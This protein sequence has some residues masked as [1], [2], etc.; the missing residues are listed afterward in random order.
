MDKKNALDRI[1]K[2]REA[3]EEYRY[4]YH[5]EDRSIIPDSAL[6]T[7]KKE[8]VDLE[9]QFPDLITPDSPSQR[10]A[11]APSKKFKKVTHETRMTSLNDVF[12]AEE[13]KAWVVRLQ[14]F[15]AGGPFSVSTESEYY[16]E[17][18]LDG[19]AIELVYEDGIFVQ[20]ATRG[21]GLVGEDVTTNLKTVDAI[22]LALYP[23]ER[24][25]KNLKKYGLDPKK[26]E[27]APK[28]LVVRG[29]IFLT[30]QEFERI[31]KE[32][33]KR[34]EKIYANPRNVA[35]GS[36]RQLDP[37]ITAARK[38]DSYQYDIV[39][40]IGVDTH[41][42]THMV[43]SAFG[44]KVNPH[45]KKAKNLK[46]A[47]A[48]REY[49][50]EHRKKLPYEVDGTVIIVN[51]NN[52]FS[53]GGIIGKA[54]RGAVAFK[55]A[56]I[57]ATTI[58]E[59]IVVQVG[60]TGALTP[61]AVLRPVAVGG[62]MITHA[63][64]H[65]AD[66]VARLD[67]RIGDTVVVSRAGDVIPKILEVIKKLRPV[68]AKSFA[69]PTICPIDGSP[70][71]KEG[72][73]HKCTN[74][75]CGAR[76]K[77]GLYHFVSRKAFDIRGLGPKILDVFLD[78]GLIATAADIFDLH[79][80]DIEALPRFGEVSARNIVKEVSEK[81]NIE[82]SRFVYAL[83]IIHV[84]EETARL[85][86]DELAK[87]NEH[88]KN[89]TELYVTG[90]QFTKEELQSV[91]DIGPV[92]AESIYAWFHDKKNERFCEV[93]TRHGVVIKKE[94]KGKM[95]TLKNAS[96]VLTGSLQTMSREEAKEKIRAYG[97]VTHESVT[98]Q[99]SYVVAGEAPGSKYEKAKKLGVP[100][101]TEPDFLKLLGK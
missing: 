56:A 47:I 27:C 81:K 67:I 23:K 46:E 36:I 101:L 93:C 72:A 76:L 55:F 2:L 74:P 38:L 71:I 22:P 42:H 80:G 30:K 60:R 32:Q 8:L 99:T 25:E 75:Y 49:W 33:E 85:L 96:F 20:G 29:E 73:I 51:E 100:I 53:A 17:L 82:I 64:L 63:T 90:A 50:E 78:N 86:A 34:G 16:C 21:D 77:E 52:I 97:G 26:I 98:K 4:A 37:K 31:N 91:S 89:P 57:D 58:V 14:N 48:F 79:E 54:P 94:K 68:N 84:G 69:M 88:I 3:I 41:E 59:D 92:V 87:K 61:V 11:G 95:Q 13:M 65:N 15:F 19:L 10:V 43:L 1:K 6:D 39:T 44:F 12:S 45:N 70:V 9:T 35:A 28:K 62:V 40:D 18:K 24:V 83:G 5:V 7:L 66:E